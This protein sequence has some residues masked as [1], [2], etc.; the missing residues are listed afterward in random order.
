VHPVGSYCANQCYSPLKAPC[1]TADSTT[2]VDHPTKSEPI[3]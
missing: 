2:Q 1:S 3:T